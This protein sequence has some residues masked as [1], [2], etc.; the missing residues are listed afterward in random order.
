[1]IDDVG[2]AASLHSLAERTE[3]QNDMTV[4]LHMGKFPEPEYE[5][6]MA[7]FRIAQEALVNSV[8]HSGANRVSMAIFQRN[9]A[10]ILAVTD[11]GEGFRDESGDGLGMWIMK[12][13]AEAQG[14]TV[15]ITSNDGGTTVEV[16]IPNEVD[17]ATD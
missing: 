2:L 5:K 9:R 16:S 3:A 11:E 14:G 7:I 10:I 6:R 8:K 4:E 15:S 12:E 13:R 17:H 1:V